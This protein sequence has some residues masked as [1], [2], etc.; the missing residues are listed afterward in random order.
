MSKYRKHKKYKQIEQNKQQLSAI[1]LRSNTHPSK[2][3][4]T[5]DN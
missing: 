3:Y 4:I 1:F 5:I 2:L